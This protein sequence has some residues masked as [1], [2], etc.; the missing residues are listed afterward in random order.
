MHASAAGRL[1]SCVLHCKL[2]AMLCSPT[3]EVQHLLEFS[4]PGVLQVCI[5]AYGQTGS[6]KVCWLPVCCK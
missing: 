3:D 2:L 6:G 1:Q 5:F 4:Q